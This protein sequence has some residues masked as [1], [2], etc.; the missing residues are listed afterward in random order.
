[1]KTP[2]YEIAVPKKKKLMRTLRRFQHPRGDG[3][4]GPQNEALRRA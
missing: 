1:M 2:R 3:S 4:S